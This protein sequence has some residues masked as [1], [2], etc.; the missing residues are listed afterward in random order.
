MLGSA[1]R[2]TS[3]TLRC[4]VDGAEAGLVIGERPDGADAAAA[5]GA[6]GTV[7]EV[8]VV[9]SPQACFRLV[10]P[11]RRS[12]VQLSAADAGHEGLRGGIVHAEGLAI[13]VSP[14]VARRRIDALALGGHLLEDRVFGAQITFGSELFSGEPQDVLTSLAVLSVAIRLYVSMTPWPEFVPS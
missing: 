13:V 4:V 7:A 6:E 1:S 3:G 12:R 8:S 9:G 11:A 10:R 2:E 14:V 5:A